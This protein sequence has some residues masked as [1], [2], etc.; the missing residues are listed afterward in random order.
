MKERR[1][2]FI[3][4]TL[5]ASF[6]A[7]SACG[8]KH[9]TTSTISPPALRT[10]TIPP[11][12]EIPS[13]TSEQIVKEEV[14]RLG[15]QPI[16]SEAHLW[17]TFGY[18][19]SPENKPINNITLKEATD[20]VHSTLTLMYNSKNPYLKNAADFISPFLR[21]EEASIAVYDDIGQKGSSM[22]T[23]SHLRDGKLHWHIR[24]QANEVLNNSSGITLALQLAHEIRHV[25]DMIIF[26]NSLPPALS[27]QERLERENQRAK[28]PKMRVEEEAR[29]YATQAQAYSVAYGFGFRGGV[30]LSHEE[31]AAQF[32]NGGS[33][34][35]SFYW[36]NYI[37][38]LINSLDQTP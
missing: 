11:T 21:S 16:E 24:I 23:S 27:T 20:R 3:A 34:E 13:K 4:S 6:I 2:S 10:S 29:G 37:E 14:Q 8:P 31:I 7:L 35:D 25:Q 17:R 30:G 26:Q 28:D 36:K 19:K 12:Q 22:T 38:K 15:I 18:N 33:K 5:A 9:E 32:I 1:V